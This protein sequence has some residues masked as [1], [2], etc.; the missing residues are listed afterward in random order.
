MSELKKAEVAP[1]QYYEIG[2]MVSVNYEPGKV[3]AFMREHFQIEEIPRRSPEPDRLYVLFGVNRRDANRWMIINS[4][5]PSQVVVI[6]NINDMAKFQ[7]RRGVPVLVIFDQYRYDLNRRHQI[8]RVMH[9]E[10]TH[11]GGVYGTDIAQEKYHQ[12]KLETGRF[13]GQPL[14]T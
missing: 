4:I 5:G 7:G 11:L 2:A 1:W 12:R 9:D 13:G 10:I 8:V 3:E 6:N 14:A